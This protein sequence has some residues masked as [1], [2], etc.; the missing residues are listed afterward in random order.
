MS[1]LDFFEEDEKEEGQGQAT[2][3][4]EEVLKRAM[5]AMSQDMRVAM[6]GIVEKYDEKTQLAVIRP[7]FKRK[8]R[9]GKVEEAPL[10]YNVPVEWMRSGTSFIHFPLKPGHSGRI[11]FHDRSMEKWTS[12]GGSVDPEDTRT[13]HM[14]DATFYPGLYPS[15]DSAP[16]NNGDD[17]II[18]HGENGK[19]ERLE[20]RLKKNGKVQIL[21]KQYDLIDVLNEAMETIR[22]AV[23]YTCGGPQKLRHT[24]L[25]PVHDKIKTFVHKG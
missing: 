14:S 6:P 16:V 13:H 20:I 3:S 15:N 12:S 17:V 7:A 24:Q 23:V 1:L 25:K 22:E 18:F 19:S 8:Y 21:N 9:D 4:L 2:P 5:Q 10:I 11:I